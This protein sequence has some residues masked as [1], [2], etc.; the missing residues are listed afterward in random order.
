M[1]VKRFLEDPF[2]EAN[3]FFP[4]L[5]VTGARQVGKTTFL[6]A[7]AEPERRFVSLDPIDVR[8]R[9]KEDPRLFL[10]DNPPPVIIDEIQY[11]PE[12]LPY[13]KAVIDETRHSSPERAKGMFWLTGSQ[14]FQLMKGVTES[15]AGRIGVFPMYGLSNREIA[16]ATEKEPFLPESFSASSMPSKTPAEFFAS[17]WMGSYPELAANPDSSKYWTRFYQSYLKSYLERDVSS[18]SQVADHNVFY[19]FLKS[20]AARSGQ[21]LN[22]SDLAR[23]VGVSQPTAK[24][25][26]SILETSGIVKLLYPYKTNNSAP[27]VSTPKLYMLDT[28]LMAFLTEWSTPEVLANGAA[29]G[30]FFE[31]WCFIEILKSYTNAGQEPSLY[32]YRDKERNPKEID[33]II[34]KDGTLYPIEFKKAATIDRDAARNFGKLATFKQP[35]GMGALVSLFPEVTHLHEDVLTIPATAL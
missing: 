34:K 19:A 10:A 23:D 8:I 2:L 12:L 13:I 15:L 18:L 29:A 26:L 3:G 5:L 1:Y 17:L 30:H 6:R 27:M 7:I 32:Y 20:V 9:A 11:A 33:I 31:T 4:A 22:Y 21:M 16:G 14:Q 35:V 24:H 28:G 25:Y